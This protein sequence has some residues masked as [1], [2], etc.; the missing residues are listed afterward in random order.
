[1]E[2]KVEVIEF[3]RTGHIAVYVG[4]LQVAKVFKLTTGAHTLVCTSSRIIHLLLLA[5]HSHRLRLSSCSPCM[6]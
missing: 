5:L 2:V 6:F 1:M 4:G 3:T